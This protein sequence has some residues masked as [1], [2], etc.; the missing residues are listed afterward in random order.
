MARM[1]NS[2]MS[3]RE[4]VDIAKPKLRTYYINKLGTSRVNTLRELNEACLSIDSNFELCKLAKER[5][6]KENNKQSKNQ[7]EIKKKKILFQCR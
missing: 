6:F 4:L 5:E 7:S 1:I 2:E 3:E